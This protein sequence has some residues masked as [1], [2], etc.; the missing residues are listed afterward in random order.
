MIT[1]GTLLSGEATVWYLVFKVVALTHFGS[2]FIEAQFE[3]KTQCMEALIA[4]QAG[5][6]ID[7][8]RGIDAQYRQPDIDFLFCTDSQESGG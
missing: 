5:H 1:L 2:E 8:Y 3:S 7:P 4:L 6:P